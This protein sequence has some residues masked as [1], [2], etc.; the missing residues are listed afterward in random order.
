M[1]CKGYLEGL[2]APSKAVV[3]RGMGSRRPEGNLID[4]RDNEHGT[5]LTNL[6]FRPH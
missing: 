1:S 2:D 3:E 6:V 5:E 4:R